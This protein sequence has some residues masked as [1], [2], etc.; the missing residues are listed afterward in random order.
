MRNRRYVLDT[1]I[2]ISY[3]VKQKT[4]QLSNV[5][6]RNKITLFSC[7]ELIIEVKRVLTYL[8]LLNYKI[9][10]SKAVKFIKEVTVHHDLEYPI[11]EYIPGDSDDNYIV[12]LALQTGSGY[13][14]SGDRH[15]LSQ[16]EA[17]QTKYRKLKILT[18]T[19]FE[20]MMK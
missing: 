16:K 4:L 13:I 15:I 17:L 19:E 6:T 8:H 10:I 9:D 18:L 7:D 20:K 1:N 2:W 12:A 5:V 14:T 3:F 11:K